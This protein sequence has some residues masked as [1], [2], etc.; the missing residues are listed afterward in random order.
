MT[1]NAAPPRL[2][3]GGPGEEQQ[4]HAA[5]A[6]LE[7]TVRIKLDGLLHGNYVGL[8][9]GP[10]T[11]PGESRQYHPG[12]DVR[13]MDWAVTARTTVPHVRQTVA[14][15]E[16]E[17]WVAVDLSPSLDFGT[18]R[19]VKRDLAVGA[20]AAITYLTQHG[21]NRIGA[22]LTTGEHT[23]R[24]PAMPGSAHARALIERAARMPRA[25]EGTRGDL[26]AMA[27][28]LRRPPR[29]RGLV[30]VVSDFLGAVPA[31][32]GHDWER[33]MRALAAR[34]EVLAIEVVDPRELELPAVGLITIAD[35]ET[36]RQVEVNTSDRALR[37][38]FAEAAAA[39]RRAIA[40][41]LRRAGAGHL[42]LSTGGDWLL[43]LVRFVAARRRGLTAGAAR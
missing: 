36:G 2:P 25:T 41:S 9:P 14:D 3:R 37:D 39:Q 11:E 5:L 8:L 23:E 33:P 42:R 35:P 21:G 32:G 27:E 17:S 28:Q 22:L 19:C 29:R 10:G 43:D 1:W 13:R 15:R 31:G 7:L 6:Q 16:L 26:A 38:R 18:A 34:H 40:A 4:L 20:L 30:V 12:D 24:I